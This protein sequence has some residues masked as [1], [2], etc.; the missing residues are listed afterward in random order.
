MLRNRDESGATAHN[1]PVAAVTPALPRLNES[2]A[3]QDPVDL[4]S[5]Q[6]AHR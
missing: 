2:L 4:P 1:T 5:R 3:L 6:Y